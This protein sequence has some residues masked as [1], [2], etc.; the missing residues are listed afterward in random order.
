MDIALINA[1]GMEK[2]VQTYYT[3]FFFQNVGVEIGQLLDGIDAQLMESLFHPFSNAPKVSQFRN[4]PDLTFNILIGP[5][6][7]HGL[8]IFGLVIQSQ[9]GQQGIAVGH[10]HRGID[11]RLSPNFPLHISRNSIQFFLP[12]DS[13]IWDKI[14]KRGGQINKTLINR[15]RKDVLH[16]GIILKDMLNL[17]IFFDILVHTRRNNDSPLGP[18]LHIVNIVWVNRQAL[19]FGIGIGKPPSIDI[20][21]EVGTSA[22]IGLTKDLFKHR[23]GCQNQAVGIISSAHDTEDCFQGVKASVYTL[24]TGIEGLHIHKGNIRLGFP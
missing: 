2:E 11:A 13:L 1:I 18:F 17:D 10:A 21:G 20:K 24:D 19:P 6:S 12:A 22:D 23:R 14:I 4:A 16:A 7:P 9:F 15:I 8:C 3:Q 5:I